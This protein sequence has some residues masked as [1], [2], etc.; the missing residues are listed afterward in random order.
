MAEKLS[1]T[2]KRDIGPV[3]FTLLG[4]VITAGLSCVSANQ[5]ASVSYRQSCLA[6]IDTKEATIR[7][8]VDSFFSAQG[9]LISLGSHR[10]RNDEELEKRL[11]AVSATAYS[12]S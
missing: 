6:R 3:W 4:I 5:T 7:G 1:R 11:D 2:S 8:K 9:S 12:L 10:I